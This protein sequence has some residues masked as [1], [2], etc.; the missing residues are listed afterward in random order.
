MKNKIIYPQEII[1]WSIIPFIRR[2]LAIELKN[3]GLDQKH[4]ANLLNL[5]EPAISNYLNEK[6]ANKK[7]NL[8]PILKKEIIKSS[9]LILSKKSNALIEIQRIIELNEIKSLIC[10]IH[11][12]EYGASRNCHQCSLGA[13]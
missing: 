4:I 7:R 13:K 2:E 6:R 8:N 11:K 1:V 9:K 3:T 5:T 10:N 12:V